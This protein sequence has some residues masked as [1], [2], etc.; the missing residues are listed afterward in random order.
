MKRMIAK[1]A[2]WIA[3]V[4]IGI[5]EITFV[6][7]LAWAGWVFAILGTILVVITVIDQL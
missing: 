2:T 7:V 3:L 6:P 4:A 1:I 5:L